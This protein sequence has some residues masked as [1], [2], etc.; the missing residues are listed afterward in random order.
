MEGRTVHCS[1]PRP[2]LKSSFSLWLTLFNKDI[3]KSEHVQKDDQN[4][5]RFGK[6][7]QQG[8]LDNGFEDPF[9]S[10]EPSS[11]FFSA[12]AAASHL[13]GFWPDVKLT[14]DN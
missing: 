7:S 1:S 4:S 2:Y 5:D 9:L 12:L 6:L 8:G 11:F 13:G 10:I 14:K 3:P